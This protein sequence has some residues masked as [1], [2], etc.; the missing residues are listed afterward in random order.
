M[1]KYCDYF[2]DFISDEKRNFKVRI[3]K[4]L[5]SSLSG[6]IAGTIFSSI[7]WLMGILFIKHLPLIEAAHPRLFL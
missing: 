6:F 1:S 5:A 3:G 7:I 4:V 2:K